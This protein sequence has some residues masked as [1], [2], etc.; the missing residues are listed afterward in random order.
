MSRSSGPTGGADRFYRVM[1]RFMQAIHVLEM[2]L[3]VVDGPDKPG[4]DDLSH[5]PSA[6]FSA[7][8]TFGALG[9]VVLANQ[10]TSLPS[11]PITY[12]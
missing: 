1:P 6:F 9:F 10:S 12:L 7:A 3:E 8:S 2:W 11:L 4:H 5:F